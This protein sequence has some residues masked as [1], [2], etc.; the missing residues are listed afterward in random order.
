VRTGR[1]STGSGWFVVL[2]SAIGALAP[3]GIDTSLPALPIMAVALHTSDGMIQAT[4][5]AFMLA[6][7][8][9]QLIVGPLSDQYG[10]RPV[11]VAGLGLFS[12][13]GLA[14][15]GATDARLLVA[16]RFVQG[17]GACAGQVVGRAIIRDVFVE[18]TQA[19]RMQ[20][21]ASAIS[22]VVPMLAPLLGV[23]LLPLG[24]RAIYAALIAGGALLCCVTAV[25]LPETLRT[26]A[27][28]AEISGVFARYRQFV[29]L[30]RSLALCVLVA[31]SFAGLFAFISGSPFV[32]VR[33][34]G[35]SRTA[36]A[37]AFAISSGSILTGS[38]LAGLVAHRIGAERLLG[39]ACTGAAIAG[40]AAFTLNVLVPHA[41]AAWQFVAVMATYAFAFGLLVPGAFAAGMEH[42]GGMAG[43]AA[44]MLGATQMLG[45]SIGSAMNGAL[46]FR[47]NVDV[48]LS[49]GVAG[50]GIAG[51]YL[52]S[53]RAARLAP[54]PQGS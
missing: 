43:V 4:L 50:I 17:L 28:G 35:L 20:A 45:G 53:V 26:R 11:I 30:P 32:L 29:A 23:A 21:Y 25:W 7:A 1:V 51:A 37:I 22:G 10:R 44:G 14:C 19:A 18:R 40:S 36:Y 48:G 5:G 34:L 42:A 15:A 13:A 41:P 52:W 8:L 3:L 46:P 49:V 16:A 38:W 12:L 24:W 54:A 27:P 9:G 31:F 39:V 6:F 2:L 33:E 47:A